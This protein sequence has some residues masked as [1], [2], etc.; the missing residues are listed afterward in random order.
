MSDKRPIKSRTVWLGFA[1][2]ILSQLASEEWIREYPQAIA[3]IGTAVGLLTVA[4]RFLTS[5]PLK[6]PF[7]D[8]V[9]RSW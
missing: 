9:P 7:D 8:S 4:L 1:V 6:P 5:E 3:W 2:A